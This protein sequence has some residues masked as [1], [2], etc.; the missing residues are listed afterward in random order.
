LRVRRRPLT[1]TLTLTLALTVTLTRTLTR[2]LALT[3]NQVRLL[4]ASEKKTR[5]PLKG[6]Q[7][8]EAESSKVRGRGRG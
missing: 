8:T 7:A 5:P 4:I 1:L 2:T 6:D 3:L